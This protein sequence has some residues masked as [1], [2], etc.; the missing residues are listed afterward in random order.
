MEIDTVSSDVCKF[1][2]DGLPTVVRAMSECP[3]EEEGLVTLTF[4]DDLSQEAKPQDNDGNESACTIAG[5]KYCD[6]SKRCVSPDEVCPVCPEAPSC[7]DACC[8]LDGP[9]D[10]CGRPT[11]RFGYWDPYGNCQDCLTTESFFNYAEDSEF[12]DKC[13]RCKDENGNSIREVFF[14]EYNTQACV[15]T[16]SICNTMGGFRSRLLE[17][18]DCQ[19]PDSA[20][21][22]TLANNDPSEC[23]CKDKSGNPSREVL[24]FSSGES[25][26]LPICNSVW[27]F[28]GGAIGCYSCPVSDDDSIETTDVNQCHKCDDVFFEGEGWCRSCSIRIPMKADPAECARCKDKNG[29]PTRAMLSNGRCAMTESAR[30]AMG[31]PRSETTGVCK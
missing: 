13:N 21:G 10:E 24:S 30:T 15:L 4:N 7:P 26:C 6:D 28:K 19:D 2:K 25:I 3:L 11:A 22:E 9:E 18:V 27:G 20:L 29:N 16:K 1:M 14:S 31:R 17:C 12:E 23:N 8:W 5:N